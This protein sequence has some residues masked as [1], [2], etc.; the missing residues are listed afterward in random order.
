MGLEAPLFRPSRGTNRR[1]EHAAPTIFSGTASV[2][3]LLLLFFF[4]FFFFYIFF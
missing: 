2:S 3:L 4:F 1:S